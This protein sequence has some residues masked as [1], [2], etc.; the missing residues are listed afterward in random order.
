MDR[1]D[2][3]HQPKVS[4][5]SSDRLA[6]ERDGDIGRSEKAGLGPCAEVSCHLIAPNDRPSGARACSLHALS[7]SER[8]ILNFEFFTNSKYS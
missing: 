5:R 3:F 7:F 1:N 4:R 2:S 6:I 8:F